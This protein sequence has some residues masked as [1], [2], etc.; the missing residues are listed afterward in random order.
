MLS[1]AH[2]PGPISA[3]L[4]GV[5]ASGW[6]RHVRTILDCSR[7]LAESVRQVRA[8]CVGKVLRFLGHLVRGALLR[9]LGPYGT[10][11]RTLTIAARSILSN[12]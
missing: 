12:V 3:H 11:V 8:R 5:D 9:W 1:V 4:S 2:K 6:L 10:N 7:F